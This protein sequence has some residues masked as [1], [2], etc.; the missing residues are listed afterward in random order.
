MTTYA[1]K[2]APACAYR[3]LDSGIHEITFNSVSR[4]AV[5]EFFVHL[6]RTFDGKTQEDPRLM[7]LIDGTA[8]GFPSLS[9]LMAGGRALV[10]NH[11]HRPQVS[12]ALVLRGHT[13]HIVFAL[14]RLIRLFRTT[15]RARSFM[16]QERDEAEAWLLR[17]R[18]IS[19]G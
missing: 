18:D 19:A 7:I 10:A 4:D 2:Q 1:P 6:N 13:R 9:E 8:S 16:P 5:T 14:E 17:D 11:P 12:Y 15:N 3:L